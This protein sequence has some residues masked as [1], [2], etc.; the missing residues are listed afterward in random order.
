MNIRKLYPT[1]GNTINFENKKFR[2]NYEFATNLNK[3]VMST[4]TPKS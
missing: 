1:I 2:E 3:K 4:R